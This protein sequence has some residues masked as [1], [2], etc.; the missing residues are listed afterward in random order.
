MKN[1]DQS[2]KIRLVRQRT[3]TSCGLAC[4]AM[5]ARKPPSEVSRILKARLKEYS[6]EHTDIPDIRFALR[7]F[8]LRLGRRVST[9]HWRKTAALRVWGL[10]AVRH[11]RLRG[12]YE[13]WHWVVVEIRAGQ[14][15][16]WDPLRNHGPHVT[17]TRFHCLG[18]ITFLGPER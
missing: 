2:A 6:S 14:P 18:I 9:R 15:V 13:R 11:K 8:G 3:G 1:F 4:V 17:S 7:E 5:L 12:G 10:A 16:V